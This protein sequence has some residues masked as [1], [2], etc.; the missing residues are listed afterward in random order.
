MTNKIL[1]ISIAAYNVADYIRETLDSLTAAKTIDQLEIFVIDDGGQDET[2]AIAQEYQQKYPNSI[3][4]IHKENGG[5]GSTVNY[6]L[7]HATGKYFRLLDGD[8]WVQTDELDTL[9]EHLAKID[10]D[11]IVNPFLRGSDMA[12]MSLVSYSNNFK[13][14]EEFL[15][16]ENPQKRPI[17]MWA[18]CYKTDVLKQSN[19]KL[20]ERLFYTDQI[21]CTVPFTVA[22]TMQYIDTKVYCYRVGRDG[23]SVS[24]ESRLKNMQ[25]T[26]DIAKMLTEFVAENKNNANYQYM[27]NRVASYNASALKTI[28][29]QPISKQSIAQFKAYDQQI[30]TISEDIFHYIA[31]ISKIGKLIYFAR[32]TNYIGLYIFKLVYPKGV[33]NWA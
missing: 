6:S 4:P 25:M 7:K 16:A 28:L 8:D 15:I 23:Q 9:V 12:N 1:T 33:P 13:D 29:L 3:F 11:V 2:L 32:K 27:I 19:L 31:S 5:Y 21:F 17:G 14:K 22:K 26:L 20:P 24:R 18:L 30:K 10:S